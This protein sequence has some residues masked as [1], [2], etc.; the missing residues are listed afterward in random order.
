MKKR[1]FVLS[2][3]MLLGTLASCSGVTNKNVSDDFVIRGVN[4]GELEGYEKL[5]SIL[6]MERLEIGVNESYNLRIMLEEEYQNAWLDIYVDN[7]DLA[8]PDVYDNINGLAIGETSVKIVVEETYY[9]ELTLVVKDQ[10]EMNKSF[11]LKQPTYL[12]RGN[13]LSISPS[14]RS[15]KTYNARNNFPFKSTC[16]MIASLSLSLSEK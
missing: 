16:L 4:D 3:L 8:K 7:F 14:A 6:A 1:L 2:S 15:A 9:D 10:D 13:A 11:K 5:N 12:D